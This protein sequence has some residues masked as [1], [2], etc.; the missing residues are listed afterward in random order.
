[1]ITLDFA[2]T[3]NIPLAMAVMTASDHFLGSE[4]AVV[5]AQSHIVF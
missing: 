5:S 1:M 2:D 3:E 4:R